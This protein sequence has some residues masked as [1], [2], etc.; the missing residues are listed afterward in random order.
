MKI[1]RQRGVINLKHFLSFGGGVNS[2]ALYLYLVEK[3]IEFEAIFADHGADYPE[4]YD[5]VEYFN[6]EL[7]NKGMKPV[8]VLNI[9]VK[10]GKMKEGLNL[11]NYCLEKQVVPS[12][13]FRWCT[14]KF[15]TKPVHQY[16]NSKLRKDENSYMH[17]GIA[18][19]ESHRAVPPKN[20]PSYMKNKIFRYVFVEDGIDR[21]GNIEIIK[22][23]GFKVP[24]KSGCFICPYMKDLEFRELY[25]NDPCL[26]EKVKEL[27][28]NVNRKRK[29]QNKDPLYIKNNRSIEVVAQE[30]QLEF[31]L[32]DH[33]YELF[34]QIKSCNCG[35]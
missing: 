20:P 8:T 21:Q 16:I 33:G 34:E 27:E 15:K 30:G 9:K 2:A 12:M 23:A 6:T 18:A 10:E 3:G 5:Y 7:K 32:K 19:D 4:T 35:L 11:I 22:N 26:Y 31:V 14:E 24:S 1:R 28:K 25:K 17:I 13:M 29:A